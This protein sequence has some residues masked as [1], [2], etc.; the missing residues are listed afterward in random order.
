MLSSSPLGPSLCLAGSKI[1]VGWL[2]A[3][4]AQAHEWTQGPLSL[5]ADRRLAC[6][7]GREDPAGWVVTGS[8][9][10]AGSQC[11][12]RENA[13]GDGTGKLGSPGPRGH[14]TRPRKRWI[15]CEGAVEVSQA[16]RGKSLFLR[17][18]GPNLYP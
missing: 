3:R 6:G 18:V 8:L 17:L 2:S 1:N 4:N 14:L 16:K 12:W 13:A 11:R 5:W 10:A 7:R 15:D 9:E